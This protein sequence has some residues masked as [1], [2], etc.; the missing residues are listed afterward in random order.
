M[1][2]CDLGEKIYLNFLKKKFGD[3]IPIQYCVFFSLK[4][5]SAIYII[6]MYAYNGIKD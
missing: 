4:K 3:I 1:L 5:T 2:G 6:G